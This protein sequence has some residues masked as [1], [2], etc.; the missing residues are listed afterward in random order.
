[1]K[2][3]GKTFSFHQGRAIEEVRC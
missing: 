2:V 1:M 3:T